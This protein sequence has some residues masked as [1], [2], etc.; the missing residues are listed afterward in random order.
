MKYLR[1]ILL[2]AGMV[3]A[4]LGTAFSL[5]AAQKTASFARA[6]KPTPVLSTADFPSVF[7]GADGKTVKKDTDGLI[8]ELE[9]VALP[10]T[11]FEIEGAVK[12]SGALIYKV[13]TAEYP[14]P[15]SGLYV[16]SRFVNVFASP[17]K[18]RIK[19][20][21]PRQTI[22]TRMLR[23]EG[24]VYVWGANDSKGIPDLLRYYP[25]AGS[26]SPRER[27][28][29]TLKGLDCS[30]LLYEAADGVTPRN[31]SDLIS[32]GKPVPVEGLSAREIAH[33][34]EPLDLIVWK[35]HVII[36]FDKTRTI[37]SCLK[38]S[39]RGGVTFRRLETVLTELM[40]NRTPVNRYPE[41]ATASKKYFVVR[42]WYP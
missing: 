24:A 12:G 34:L 15:P 33:R 23:N 18:P 29:W 28:L 39:P 36:V 1:S 11:V 3:T 4:F 8:R 41:S 13:R 30:G 14:A 20:L 25:P 37:E 26:L 9:F 32:F 27:D 21:P 40:K 22:L 10:G 42:R 16:D 35:G 6:E 38:C 19:K 5:E 7:G 17:P 2:G 31:T